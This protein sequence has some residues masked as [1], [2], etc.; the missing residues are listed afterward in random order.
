MSL[1]NSKTFFS[2][3]NESVTSGKISIEKKCPFCGSE[4]TY[5][6]T[7]IMQTRIGRLR[8]LL[9]ALDQESETAFDT[10]YKIFVY[11]KHLGG[12]DI[13]E[14]S[15]DSWIKI[16]RQIYYEIGEGSKPS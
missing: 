5:E 13:P 6:D 3:I 12:F 10:I 14:D 8:F 11:G 16:A 15:P 7:K 2:L 9:R 1:R 4:L